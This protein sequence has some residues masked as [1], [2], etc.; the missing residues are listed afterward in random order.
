MSRTSTDRSNPCRRALVFLLLLAGR[1]AGAQQGDTRVVPE[2]AEK[3]YTIPALEIVG[4]DLLLSRYNRRFSG[5]SDYDVTW[6]SIRHN[7]R[8]PWVTDNDPFRINQFGHPY[9]GSIYHGAARSTG[10]GYWEASALTFAG[11]AWW[12][13]TGEKTPPSYNDQVA[14]GVAGSFL[15][16]PLFR[17]AHL[18]LRGDSSLPQ[19]WREWGAAAVS[20]AVGFN[21]LIYGSRFDGAFVDNQPSYNARLRLGTSHVTRDEVGTSRVP[22]RNEAVI[23]F[24]LDYGLPGKPGYTYRRPFDHFS[25]RVVA[26]TDHGIENLATRGLLFGT[27]YG[28]GDSYRGIWGLYGSYDYFAPQIFHISTTA[29]S[30]GTT[31]Q[32]WLSQDVALQGSAHAG[33]GYSAA[34]TARGVTDDRDYHYGMAP[35]ASLALRLL[36]G[37]RAMAEVSGQKYYLG[38]IANRSAGRD[39]I[40]RI[41]SA[42]TLRIQGP[43]A[44]ALRY[45][46]SHRSATYPVTGDRSQTLG[47]I[48]IYY[49]LLGGDDFG[50]TEWRDA[51]SR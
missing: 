14:S 45:V 44:V 4:F 31:G 50:S 30:L 25:F 19:F 7:L 24:A 3:S 16:E 15:G 35:R 28:I 9:Q 42:L 32:W 40:S 48:G 37:T 49:T 23:D 41:E 1:V 34:S 27:D 51:S 38:S 2:T 46:W 43:H 18:I 47:T 22:S 8:G 17:M 33:F 12:E 21:R 13:I 39:D 29:L 6:R 20:P 36:A 10:L 5:S 26:T 11:S